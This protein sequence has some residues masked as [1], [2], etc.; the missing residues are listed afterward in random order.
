MEREISRALPLN[1]QEEHTDYFNRSSVFS[2]KKAS[3]IKIRRAFIFWNGV[4]FKNGEVLVESLASPFFATRY[5]R[6]F[7]ISCIFK[8]I[9][10]RNFRRLKDTPCLII[11]DEWGSNYFHWLTDAL[12]RLYLAKHLLERCTLLLPE[13]FQRSYHSYTLKKFGVENILWADKKQVF[14]VKELFLP[15]H[16]APASNYN[17]ELLRNAVNFLIEDNQCSLSQGEKI[18]IS[19]EKATIRKITNEAAVI[20]FLKGRGFTILFAEDFSF[21][22][23]V[24]IFSR[25]R[26][27]VSI[28]GSGLTNLMFMPTES[29]VLEFRN[30]RNTSVENNCYFNLAAVF[31]QRYFYLA[32]ETD[33]ELREQEANIYVDIDALEENLALMEKG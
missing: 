19:R 14:S 25:A 16:T 12:T 5:S 32:C 10:S 29:T 21:E 27:L 20:S 23:Q 17:P 28:H 1:L 26:T 33:S 2:I 13:T 3:I 22:E 7:L 11:Y 15:M 24:S 6:G 9:L 31:N 18:Y 8:S 4:V 30:K